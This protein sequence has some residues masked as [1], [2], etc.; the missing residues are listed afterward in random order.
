[1]PHTE[2]VPPERAEAALKAEVDA[3]SEHDE[4][5]WLMADAKGRRFVWRLLKIAGIYRT[6]FAGDALQSA[7]REGYRAA[8]IDLVNLI[9]KHCPERYA[10]MQKEARTNGN[11][12]STSTKP[13]ASRAR[14]RTEYQPGSSAGD[15]SG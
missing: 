5:C 12:T 10:Q 13:R 15:A 11:S 8:G 9:L 7:F 3:A 1:M 2:H 4:V 6:T 14:S